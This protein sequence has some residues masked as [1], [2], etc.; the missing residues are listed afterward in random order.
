MADSSVR[1]RLYADSSSQRNFR[2]PRTDGIDRAL[3]SSALPSCSMTS[4]MTD[5]NAV[6]V[7][8]QKVILSLV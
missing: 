5:Y 4:P 7:R 1:L 6:K 8:L 2:I 3:R